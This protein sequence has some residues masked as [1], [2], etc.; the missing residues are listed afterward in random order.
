M[1]TP[2]SFEARAAPPPYP[3]NRKQSYDCY[4]VERTSSRAGV[5]PAEVQRLFTAHFLAN[6]L[7]V[8]YMARCRA[9]Y[10]IHAPNTAQRKGHGL[11]LMR[12]REAHFSTLIICPDAF[13][14]E[15]VAKQF[16]NKSYTREQFN[17]CSRATS[18]LLGSNE[19]KPQAH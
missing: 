1:E 2:A 4:R 15:L 17:R 18:Y 14:C 11:S 6:Y 5:A 12:T 10:H 16:A 8:D 7:S 9:P 13:H 3:A 19:E